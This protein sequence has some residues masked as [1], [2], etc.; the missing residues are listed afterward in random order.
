MIL[1]PL[2]AWWLR[3]RIDS[4][5]E[6][7]LRSSTGKDRSGP[8]AWGVAVIQRNNDRRD[9]LGH[10]TAFDDLLA[11]LRVALS[12]KFPSQPKPSVEWWARLRALVDVLTP[13]DSNPSKE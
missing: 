3:Q 5:D 6:T 12:S 9:A 1:G 13:P 4:D 2:R 8:D 10:L 11:H 7:L